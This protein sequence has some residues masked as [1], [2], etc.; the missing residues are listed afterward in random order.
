MTPNTNKE[1]KLVGVLIILIFPINKT[2]M[3]NFV[4]KFGVI[5]IVL[6]S[7]TLNFLILKT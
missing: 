7:Q 2:T 1:Y 5:F 4:A 6:L 3:L